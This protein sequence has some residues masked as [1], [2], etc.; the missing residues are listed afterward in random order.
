MPFEWRDSIVAEALTWLR[1]PYHHKGRVKGVGV[2]CGGLI[3]ESYKRVLGIPAEPFPDDYP[4]DWSMHKDGNELYL[5]FIKPYIRPT[6]ELLPADLVVFKFGRNFAHGTIYVGG[7][8]VIHSYGKT[9]FGSV[10]VTPMTRFLIGN[11]PRAYKKYTLDEQW[12]S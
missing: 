3:Y 5:D 6:R 12:R 11:Q 4:E 10:V 2:D 9:G 7:G 1:T 8:N